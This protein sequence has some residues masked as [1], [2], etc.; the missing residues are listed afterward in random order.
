L[1]LADSAPSEGAPQLASPDHPSSS[2][3][4]QSGSGNSVSPLSGASA[5]ACDKACHDHVF[6]PDGRFMSIFCGGQVSYRTLV[7][8][9]TFDGATTWLGFVENGQDHLF[10]HNRKDKS[11]SVYKLTRE[12]PVEVTKGVFKD[13]WDSFQIKNFDGHN[14]LFSTNAEKTDTGLVTASGYT[15]LDSQPHVSEKLKTLLRK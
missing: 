2:A 11:F 8:T 1:G 9:H 6:F 4:H 7:W 5:G 14:L 13:R 15:L 12:G 3:A 10:V